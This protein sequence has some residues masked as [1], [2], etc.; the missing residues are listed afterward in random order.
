M[1][2]EMQRV[3][4]EAAI[5]RVIDRYCHAVDRGTADDVVALF[6][7]T[8]RLVLTLEDND[9][10]HGRAAVRA[11]YANYHDNFR[12]KLTHLRHKISNIQI[13]LTGDEARVVSYM[14]ADI[15]VQGETQPCQAI[16]RYDDRFVREGGAWYFAEKAIIGY[17]ADERLVELLSSKG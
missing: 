9:G 8:G 12:A 17:Y 2:D 5:R 4:D 14:D 1:S 10:Y 15:I 11:W 13:D 16:G 7:P 3:I 6:H